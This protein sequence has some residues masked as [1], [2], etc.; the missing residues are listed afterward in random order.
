MRN[1]A[2]ASAAASRATAASECKPMRADA[3]RNRAQL[4]DAASKAFLSRG[5]DVPMEEIA[6]AAGVGVGTLYRHFPQRTNLI[7]AVYRQEVEKLCS[8]IDDLL[9]AQPADE[10]LAAWMGRFIEYIGLKRGLMDALRS[11]MDSESEVFAHV[12]A[13]LRDAVSTL[14]QAAVDSGRIRPDLDPLDVLRA[15]SGFGLVS[16]NAGWQDRAR[17]LVDI[18]MDGLRVGAPNP[19]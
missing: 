7:E 5:T 1:A 11:T 9:A 19:G 14:V 16:S 18:F 8:G 13:A 4:V 3:V 10:A 17:R 2:P 15:V 6:K 12:A